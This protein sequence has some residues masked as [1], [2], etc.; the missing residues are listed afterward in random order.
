[1]KRTILSVPED[2]LERVRLRA[3]EEGVS[4]AAFMRKAIE[5]RLSAEQPKPRCLGVGASGHTDTG[6]RTADERPEPRAWR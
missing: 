6:R 2:L 3:A 1:M 4:M 5:E